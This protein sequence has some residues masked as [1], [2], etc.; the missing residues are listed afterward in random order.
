[1]ASNFE[2][3]MTS[4]SCVLK[5][6]ISHACMNCSATFQDREQL[7]THEL[8]HSPTGSVNCKIC[9]KQFANVY[10]LQRHMLS[11]DESDDL[12][13]FKCTDCDKAF[14]FKHHLKEHLRI[15]SGEKPFGCSNCGKR[16]SHS[17]SFS[18]HMTSKKC[19]NMGLKIN[20]SNE[21]STNKNEI[22]YL[23]IDAQ[24]FLP[25]SNS[26]AAAAFLASFPNPFLSI[27]PLNPNPFSIQQLLEQSAAILNKHNVKKQEEKNISS[28]T[29]DMNADEVNDEERLVMDINDPSLISESEILSEKNTNLSPAYS[30]QICNL[31]IRQEK[32]DLKCSRCDKT[33]DHPTQLVQH[34]KVL[35]TSL[36]ANQTS[37]RNTDIETSKNYIKNIFPLFCGPSGSD[38][39]DN[40]DQESKFSGESERKVRVRTAISDDQQ[41][42]L[43]RHYAIN[44]RP[45][46]DEFR[47]IADQL[48]LDPRVVQVWFQNNRSRERKL[49]NSSY[50]KKNPQQKLVAD[51]DEPLDLSL[52]KES[53][54]MKN[55]NTSDIFS[56][57]DVPSIDEAI[58]LSHKSL[59]K[60][61]HSS[62]TYK[63]NSHNLL[64]Q[65]PVANEVPTVNVKIQP[66]NRNLTSNGLDMIPMEQLFQIVPEMARNQFLNYTSNDGIRRSSISPSSSGKRSWKDDDSRV[67]Y[68]DDKISNASGVG[69]KLYASSD[70]KEPPNSEG[71][72]VCDLCEKAFHKQSSL[73]RHKYEHSGQRPYKCLECPKA[74]KHKHH[75]TEHK[76]LHT[77]EKPFQCCKCLKKFSHSG[78]YSQ[79]MNHRYSYC[80]PYRE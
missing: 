56:C 63:W 50:F 66:N 3:D 70:I 9:S 36:H 5:V 68:D 8:M 58:N 30:G 45:N 4:R 31:N 1:M 17:G 18:S 12:R 40:E 80:K 37:D 48:H 7:E 34:E 49:E 23:G 28:D 43:K 71:M 38:N 73:A 52:K 15:H 14:K 10:R 20:E 67:S 46:R 2:Y 11:H 75:L 65:I 62:Y 76:R 32:G 41:I 69:K 44:A 57:N 6:G 24:Q 16:F 13:K 55:K 51:F 79:H 39:D 72:Y 35:C 27:A 59:K 25:F 54:S 33:F 21:S 53:I 47:S 60:N 42:V 64:R 22:G 26:N 78:S 19:I 29:E 61:T 74:F 77:G